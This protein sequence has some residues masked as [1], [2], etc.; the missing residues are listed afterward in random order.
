MK[1]TLV[2]MAA[3]CLN[4]CYGQ[5]A[6]KQSKI[7]FKNAKPHPASAHQDYVYAITGFKSGYKPGYRIDEQE[8]VKGRSITVRNYNIIQLYKLA[9]EAGVPECAI[10]S[11]H[12]LVDVREPKKLQAIHCFKLVVPFYQTDN[13]YIIMQR[14]LNGEFS[15]YT[16][17]MESRGK[18]SFM[19]IRDREY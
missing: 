9:L 2:L 4:F 7:P 19:V 6:A 8:F 14:C 16:V 15:E 3:L 5:E 18:E 1:T 12:I 10:D 13:F 11:A 17:K